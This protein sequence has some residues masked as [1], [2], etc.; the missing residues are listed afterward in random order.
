[1]TILLHD[2]R[3]LFKHLKTGEGVCLKRIMFGLF[4]ILFIFCPNMLAQGREGDQETLNSKVES[5]FEQ[6]HNRA[7]AVEKKALKVTAQAISN[8][9]DIKENEYL[10]PPIIDILT[11]I[12]L[13]IT[14]FFVILYWKETQKM[15]DE[16]ITQNKISFE[17]IKSQNMPLVDL[18][19]VHIKDIQEFPQDKPQFA[20]DLFLINKGN[21]PAFKIITKRTID[22]TENRQRIA[23]NPPN[24]KIKPFRKKD[25]VLGRGETIKILREDSTSYEYMKIVVSYRDHFG[26]RHQCVFKGDRDGIQI[27][28]HPLLKNFYTKTEEKQRRK[29]A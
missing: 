22:S 18:Q 13:A 17:N 16:M 20:Y 23:L 19:M 28:D 25:S 10:L 15:K 21:G 29:T 8:E 2:N 6:G 7:V 24:K 11:L 1:M 3:K 27:V 14:A 5:Q 12:I 26:E 9:A 4:A